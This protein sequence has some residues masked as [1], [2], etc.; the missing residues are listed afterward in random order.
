MGKTIDDLKLDDTPLPAAGDGGR[1]ARDV[2]EAPWYQFSEEI[3]ELLATGAYTWAE[4]TLGA[5]QETVERIKFVTE[6]QR[7]AVEN[8]VAAGERR[9]RGEHGVG[10]PRVRRR[11]EGFPHSRKTY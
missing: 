7:Q 3:S 4:G 10:A 5:I 8:I 11:Y 1:R 2:R 6:G 9:L